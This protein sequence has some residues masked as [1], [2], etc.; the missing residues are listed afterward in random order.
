MTLGRFLVEGMFQFMYPCKHRSL[1]R[2][3]NN[4]RPPLLALGAHYLP[5]AWSTIFTTTEKQW[6]AE[7]IPADSSVR[8]D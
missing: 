4:G 7:E 1:E 3:D 6:G 8:V 5:L 2:A